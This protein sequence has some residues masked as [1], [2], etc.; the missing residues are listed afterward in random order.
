MKERIKEIQIHNCN[1]RT[2][3]YQ[4]TLKRYT[5]LEEDGWL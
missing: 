3:I 2:D 1:Y 5:Q 4:S